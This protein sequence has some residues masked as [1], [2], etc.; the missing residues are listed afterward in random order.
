LTNAC[1]LLEIAQ[2]VGW[3]IRVTPDEMIG[4]VTGAAR[5]VS[6]AGT[7]PG[8][9]AGGAL[10]DHY[11]VRVPIVVSG[12]G[13]LLMAISVFANPALRDERR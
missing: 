8:A 13:Y 12:I 2:I 10:A 4:R 9:I 1:V 7:V 5:L 6:L 3:R 11:G